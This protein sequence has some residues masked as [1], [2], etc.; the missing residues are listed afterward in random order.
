[1]ISYFSMVKL[2]I[3]N[4]IVMFCNIITAHFCV[5]SRRRFVITIFRYTITVTIIRMLSI[6]HFKK[7]I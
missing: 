6:I 4:P 5:V 2:P 3:F 7:R 1:M